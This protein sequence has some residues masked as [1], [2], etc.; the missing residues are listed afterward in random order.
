MTQTGEQMADECETIFNDFEGGVTDAD[1]TESLSAEDKLSRMLTEDA[2]TDGVRTATVTRLDF[3]ESENF[4]KHR[5]VAKV[6]YEVGG[7]E[8][9]SEFDPRSS[10]DRESLRALLRSE[11]ID[12]YSGA[13]LCGRDVTIIMARD[14]PRLI[15]DEDISDEELADAWESRW[16]GYSPQLDKFG[17]RG[18]YVGSA[19]LLGSFLLSVVAAEL[20]AW[21]WVNTILSV[22]MIVGIIGGFL[23]QVFGLGGPTPQVKVGQEVQQD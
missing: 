3:G 10:D 20:G 21:A 23:I 11:G 22:G 18:I 4:R 2:L 1:V 9:C 19:L 5:E 6:H 17:V 7:I 16:L 15:V 14:R 13:N 12:L 8:W